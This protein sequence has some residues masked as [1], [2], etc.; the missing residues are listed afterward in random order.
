MRTSRRL[1]HRSPYVTPCIEVRCSLWY[2]WCVC[3]LG[4]RRRRDATLATLEFT[5]TDRE[6]RVRDL[7]ASGGTVTSVYSCTLSQTHTQKL[8][9]MFF[10]IDSFHRFHTL[11]FSTI[12]AKLSRISSLISSILPFQF[13][14]LMLHVHTLILFGIQAVQCVRFR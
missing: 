7:V 3:G 5:Q 13:L 12:L 6:V 11:L 4:A 1:V 9:I 2:F 10:T 8:S 14:R